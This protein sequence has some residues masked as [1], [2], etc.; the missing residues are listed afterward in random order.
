MKAQNGN[1]Y[2]LL[3]Q[4]F[5]ILLRRVPDTMFE[6]VYNML[7]CDRVP[8]RVRFH[9]LLLYNTLVHIPRDMVYY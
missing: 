3:F 4:A 5:L 7:T 2:I 8:G 6:L 9:V 1:N